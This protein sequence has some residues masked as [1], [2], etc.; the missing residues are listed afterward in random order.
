MTHRRVVLVHPPRAV[1][2]V[3]HLREAVVGGDGQCRVIAK[4][5]PVPRA[6]ARRL[7]R[8]GCEGRRLYVRRREAPLAL[9]GG[10]CKGR[11]ALHVAPIPQ[12]R[13]RGR[14]R[15]ICVADTLPHGAP[16]GAS[17]HSQ[18]VACCG[19]NTDT[20][21][22]ARCGTGARGR[23]LRLGHVSRYWAAG[24]ALPSPAE[25]TVTARV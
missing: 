19:R 20:G 17:L 2:E 3:E 24:A 4:L 11:H 15:G 22:A 8:R 18:A 12:L 10:V 6:V 23:T 7:L 25:A 9:V 1:G 5:V 14:A 16:A 21:I 13:S